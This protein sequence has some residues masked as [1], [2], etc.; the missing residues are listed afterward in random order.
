M[1][2]FSVPSWSLARL[3]NTTPARPTSMI[4]KQ[5]SNGIGYSIVELNDVRHIF[6]AAAPRN[7]GSLAEQT[8]DA[9]RT[10]ERLIH[11]KGTCGSIVHQAVFMRQSRQLD[12]CRR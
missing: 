5:S 6:A 1:G 10:I 11:E 3:T 2:L 7:G 12:E 4:R 8:R 9:L